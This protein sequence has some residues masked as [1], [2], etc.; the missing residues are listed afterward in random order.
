MREN[1]ITRLNIWLK[2]PL[3]LLLA[4]VLVLTS[5][6]FSAMIVRAEDSDS[7]PI[8]L[9]TDAYSSTIYIYSNL[10]Y[11][12][13]G[14]TEPEISNG[15]G[16]I[17]SKTTSQ[18]IV[19]GSETEKGSY[20]DVSF[21]NLVTPSMTILPVL[22][23]SGNNY[24]VRATVDGTSEI[25]ALELKKDAILNLTLNADLTIDS[26]TLSAN[27][28]LVVNT[29]GYKLTFNTLSVVREAGSAASSVSFSGAGTINA[30]TIQADTL[31]VNGSTLTASGNIKV[32]ETISLENADITLN[33]GTVTAESSITVKNTTVK[34]VSLFGFTKEA[35]G[36]KT[37]TL[38]SAG[39]DNSGLGETPGVVGAEAGSKAFVTITGTP[40]VQA[41]TNVVQDYKIS[42]QADGAALE[43]Q[44][45]W[46]AAYR[47]TN[48]VVS[49]YH[50]SAEYY[51]APEGK[52]T[53]PSYTKEGY[54]YVGWNVNG[55]NALALSGEL[56]GDIILTPALQAGEVAITWDLD[57]EPSQYTNDNHESVLKETVT[58][59]SV[60]GTVNL[61]E[62]VP[63]RFGY[64]FAGWKTE[65]G[66]SID[67]DATEFTVTL[68]ELTAVDG[69]E[70]SYTIKMTA[71]W[72]KDKFPLRIY[73]GNTVAAN[74]LKVS[75]DGGT[76][77]ELVSNVNSRWNQVTYDASQSTLD[78]TAWIEYEKTLGKYFEEN[79]M[80]FPI[81]ED[82]NKSIAFTA[83]KLLGSGFTVDENTVYS[84]ESGLLNKRTLTLEAYQE[85]L[86]E[87]K[88]TLEAVW[89]T[90]SY[91]LTTDVVSGWTILVDGTP[92]TL[93]N[94]SATI[95][96][97]STVTYQCANTSKTGISPWVF[98]T[99]ADGEAL[100]QF[101]P[102]ERKYTLGDQVFYY[103][104]TMPM[105]DVKAT[106]SD[107]AD[108]WLNLYD[109][110]ITFED[111]LLYNEV[112][113]DGFWLTKP[114]KQLTYL[115][116]VA[117]K[118]FFY[119]WDMSKPVQVTSNNMPTQ[120]QL[121]LKEAT[122]VYFKDCAMVAREAYSR[123]LV[124]LKMAGTRIENNVTNAIQGKTLSDY[125]NIVLNT[126][127]N[128]KYTTKLYFEGTNTLGAV[129]PTTYSDSTDYNGQI[130]IYG[131]NNNPELNL[132]L[133]FGN[134]KITFSGL[135]VRQY[136]KSEYQSQF[137]DYSKFMIYAH[138]VFGATA[139]I[140]FKGCD[141]EAEDK[142]L[143]TA[144]YGLYCQDYNGIGTN[145][146]LGYVKSEDFILNGQSSVHIMEDLYTGYRTG[147]GSFQIKGTSS[148]VVDGS[149]YS[150][151]QSG[152]SREINTSGYVIVKGN[153]FS[154]DGLNLKNGTVIANATMIGTW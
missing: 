84:Y 26:V 41:N 116:E 138:G 149:I 67:K 25:T 6:D 136:N 51:D 39:F 109:S 61:S 115:Y 46:P 63:Y 21:K 27:S 55:S 147:G 122:T 98:S 99:V 31:S 62:R 144:Y 69:Q 54:S 64:T 123:D 76:N 104:F 11:M 87:E 50:T 19:I 107:L 103:D 152:A 128:K 111:S 15:Q 4:L 9:Q 96:A 114:H 5:A 74:N 30:G 52:V 29:N 42:Y 57:Y 94:G 10:K 60:N 12:K 129:F 91:T 53:L 7:N 135:K 134:Y 100:D 80:K 86:K 81:L 97:G 68:D 36:N 151:Y 120:N 28:K 131:R 145:A 13:A 18:S 118:G 34:N 110:P 8:E 33:G 142:K 137:P 14:E 90:M 37:I 3:A 139:D 2:R 112:K 16:Y 143:F 65:K 95:K 108:V 73:V 92:I 106:Y 71:T 130:E 58:A 148:L 121:T 89:G 44:N 35:V 140:V 126:E 22:G 24:A 153:Q 154:A 88:I 124:D 125:A 79:G 43:I 133:I 117:D 82:A 49:G 23:D 83:W 150:H 48:G 38:N 70:N 32:D 141:V 17:L 85:K 102:T 20:I 132:G 75:F 77:W 59:S 119:M 1:R 146:S 72:K 66:T 78:L 45:D 56:K 93:E 105:C 40:N 113:R 127:P 101:A 47:V